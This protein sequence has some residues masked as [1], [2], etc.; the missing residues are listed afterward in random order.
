M[1]DPAKSPL[2]FRPTIDPSAT[3]L[4]T[5]ELCPLVVDYISALERHAREHGVRTDSVEIS[6][7]QDPEDGG[8]ELVITQHVDLAEDDVMPCWHG[9][10]NALET[11]VKGLAKDKA[12]RVAEWIALEVRPDADDAAA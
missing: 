1:I 12:Q 11:W 7:F 9:A 10:G 3:P 5:E 6:G 2:P 4:L 8:E